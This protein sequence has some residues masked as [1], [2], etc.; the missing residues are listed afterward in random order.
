MLINIAQGPVGKIHFLNLT[1]II[2]TCNAQLLIC[3]AKFKTV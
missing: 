3:P 1:Q 2:T